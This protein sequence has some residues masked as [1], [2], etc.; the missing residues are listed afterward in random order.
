MAISMSGA[1]VETGERDSLKSSSVDVSIAGNS[2]EYGAVGYFAGATLAGVT[3]DFAT[4]VSEKIETYC[5][6]VNNKVEELSTVEVNQAFR[7][8]EI[9]TAL[10]NFIES[11]KAVAKSYTDKLQ[12]AETEI[13]NSVAQAYQTQDTDL[14]GNLKSDSSSL[15]STLVN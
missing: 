4:S 9:E 15:E 2:P 1:T 10:N 13:I 12:A 14:S 7:G 8:T 11:V 5:T 3:A 6:E